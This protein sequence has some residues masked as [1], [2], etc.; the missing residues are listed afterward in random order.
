M[1]E[2]SQIGSIKNELKAII[3]NTDKIVKLT[4]LRVMETATVS[5]SHY[6]KC[7]RIKNKKPI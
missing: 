5:K 4:V 7:N 1:I 2:A 3:K 6:R